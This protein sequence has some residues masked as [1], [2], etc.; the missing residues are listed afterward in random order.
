M[1]T[2]SFSPLFIIVVIALP[3]AWMLYA[4][5]NALHL[6]ASTIFRIRSTIVFIFITICILII[7]SSVTPPVDSQL[8]QNDDCMVSC[9]N[10]LIV[11]TTNIDTVYSLK[12]TYDYFRESENS[13]RSTREDRK[14]FVVQTT[15]GMRIQIELLGGIVSQIELTATTGAFSL[16]LRDI[17]NRLGRTDYV[18][19]YYYGSSTSRMQV[20][21]SHITLFYPEA[22]YIVSASF[23][24]DLSGSV[25]RTCITG[26]EL[27]N[28]IL[29]VKV[30]TIDR[31]LVDLARQPRA[32]FED[33]LHN[34]IL[35]GLR[36]LSRFGCF[37]M[38]YPP[39][40]SL[41]IE[42]W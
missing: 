31:V 10:N 24:S 39:D 28:N 5:Q 7:R 13:Q 20:N 23:P 27:I 32:I 1:I 6:S 18:L 2:D 30:N 41:G 25:V 34:F 11:G 8:F 17:I 42:S 3:V 26:D 22:G 12:N 33:R 4:I 19:L 15:D 38:P 16:S 21:T 37:Q 35:N 14:E 9:W 29:I 40:I 36:P